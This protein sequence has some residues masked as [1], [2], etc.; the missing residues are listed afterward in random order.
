MS[1]MAGGFPVWAG[2]AAA[3]GW[4]TVR[5]LLTRGRLLALGGFLAL[6]AFIAFLYAASDAPLAPERF[7]ARL[8]DGLVLTTVLPLVALVFGGA[9]F[10]NEVEDGTLFYLVMKPG[11][12]VALVAAKYTATATVS[13]T[14]VA[15]SVLAASALA[16]QDGATL[17]T[18]VAFAVASAAG[19][20]AYSG[21]FLVLGLV[22][23]RVLVAGLA[24]I[25]LWEGVLS[26]LFAGVRTLSIR[27]YTRTVAVALADLPANVLRADLTLGGALLGIALVAGVSLLLATYR[28]ATM[29]VG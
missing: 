16:G 6:P 13:A 2:S 28:L 24:Y 8:C 18:G 27:E 17:R 29:D 7:L 1:G 21:L 9:A 14:A 12:R 23:T 20:V 15:L 19:A 22:T 10:G 25:F 11:P 3:V 4:L 26:A 5:Q